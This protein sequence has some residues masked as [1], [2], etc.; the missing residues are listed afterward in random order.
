MA[1]NVYEWVQDEYHS[2]YNG[3]P[4]DGNGWCA[5]DC[6]EN[7][8]DSNYN[9]SDSASRVIRGGAWNGGSSFI[10][11]ANRSFISPSYQHYRVGARLSR[12][13]P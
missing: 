1:G 7:A 5:S 9:A 4:N 13:I 8:S 10:R 3:A 2:D 11:S 6:P 12:S